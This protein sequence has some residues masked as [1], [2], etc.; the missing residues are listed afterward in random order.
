MIKDLIFNIKNLHFCVHAFNRFLNN[1]QHMI[2]VQYTGIFILYAQ[3]KKNKIKTMHN[4]SLTVIA[5]IY[6]L[7]IHIILSFSFLL[8]IKIRVFT[9]NNQFI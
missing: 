6:S 3:K 1:L 4:C 8:K 9:K 7:L 5:I 2:S